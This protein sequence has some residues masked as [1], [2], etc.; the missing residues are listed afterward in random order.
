M[1]HVLFLLS[2]LRF[3]DLNHFGAIDFPDL[4][5]KSFFSWVI[6]DFDLNK[7]TQWSVTTLI[8]VVKHARSYSADGRRMDW[9][10][11]DCVGQ[12]VGQQ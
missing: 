1:S 2:E 7:K 3:I 5:Y 8:I 4:I 11:S 10:E 12:P 9:R 6:Y